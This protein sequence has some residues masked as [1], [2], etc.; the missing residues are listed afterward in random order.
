MTKEEAILFIHGQKNG[1]LTTLL[2]DGRPHSAPIVYAA[3]NQAIEISS[4]WTRV[5][6]KNLMRDP[7]ASLCILPEDGWYPYLTVEG[8]AEL[9]DDPKGQKNLSLYRR[10]TG[11]DPDDSADYLEAMK[12]EKRHIIRLSIDRLYPVKG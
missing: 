1:V 3:D 10:I 7:R 2:K 8:I 9:I 4:C 6:T 11:S 5:K 12:R